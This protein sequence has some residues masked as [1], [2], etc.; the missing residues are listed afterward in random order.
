MTAD[1]SAHGFDAPSPETIREKALFHAEKYCGTNEEIWFLM[2]TDRTYISSEL[3][4]VSSKAPQSDD[5]LEVLSSANDALRNVYKELQ[6]AMNN[7]KPLVMKT[8]DQWLESMID[9]CAKAPDD[10]FTF[11]AVAK[12]LSRIFAGATSPKIGDTTVDPA[13]PKWDGARKMA[14]EGARKINWRMKE[15]DL[16]RAVRNGSL[17]LAKYLLAEGADPDHPDRSGVTPL[18]Y[19]AR[20]SASFLRLLIDS[21]ADLDAQDLDG[22][23]AVEWA[24]CGGKD[25]RRESLRLLAKAPERQ[26]QI[27]MHSIAAAKQSALKGRRKAPLRINPS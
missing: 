9:A 25:E 1:M 24:Q 2:E 17:L 16:A 7:P 15:G 27:T 4:D 18:M 10:S 11:Y 22:S 19:A 5:P 8:G 20:N 26:R 14:A 13:D 6:D 23:T 21:G 3:P 12:M